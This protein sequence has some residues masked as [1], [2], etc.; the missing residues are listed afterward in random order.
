VRGELTRNK[1]VPSRRPEVGV[2]NNVSGNQ[3]EFVTARRL[4][5]RGVFGRRKTLQRTTKAMF[6]VLVAGVFIAKIAEAQQA[7]RPGARKY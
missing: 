7:N 4:R 3:Q 2:S 1:K 5:L 6:C